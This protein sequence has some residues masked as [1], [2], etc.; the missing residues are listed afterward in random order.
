M[1]DS[2]VPAP[3]G[4]PPVGDRRDYLTI[5]SGT[6]QNLIG[7]VIAALATAGANV[8]LSRVLGREG[9]GVVTLITQAAFVASF[10][11]RAGMDMAVLREVAIDVG[12]GRLDR[13]RGTVAHAAAIA[14]AVSALVALVSYGAAGALRNAFSIDPSLGDWTV[15]AAAVGLPFLAIT[16][17]WLAATRGLKIMRHT[18]YIF[19]AGQPLAWIVLMA[20][21][22]QLS[23]TPWMAVLAYSISWMGAGVAAW[24]AWRRAARGWPRSLVPPD[25]LGRLIRYAGPRAPAALFS[26]MLFWT[27]LFILTNYVGD[28]E[29]GVYSAVLRAGQVVVLFLTSVNLMFSPYV[30]DLHAR[31]ERDR[32][33]KLFMTLTRWTLAATL[34]AFI[35]LAVTPA[36]VLR[37]F[38]EGFEG[39]RYALMILLAGQLM[40]IATGSVGFVLIMVGRTTADLAVYAASFLF[41]VVMAIVLCSRYGIEGAAAANALTFALS[42]GVRLLLVRRFVGIQP[43]D[44]AYLGLLPA[45]AACTLAMMALHALVNGGWAV[46]LLITGF[47]GGL[48][49]GL[50]YLAVGLTAAE[51][52]VALGILGR[53][54]AR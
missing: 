19:W 31:G 46:D 52:K 7:I 30:A 33:D 4:D 15:E 8:M 51:R 44:R 38:G 12:A 5:L 16:N 34:P 24:F 50:V 22:W 20:A 54:K 25:D 26:Q 53:G 45:A 6:S 47:G 2:P 29:V 39:G 3:P 35:L 42:N 11:T 43:Y 21:G 48:V 10:A 13:P 37:I 17:V 1:S 27:D 23:E 32:L 36:S 28:D 40:N 14:G 49:Y 41:D 18:L 9:F